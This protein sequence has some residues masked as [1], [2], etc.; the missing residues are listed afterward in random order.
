MLSLIV[1]GEAIFTLPFHI[2]RY[3]RPSFVEV[4]ALTQT[5][6]GDML[7]IYGVVATIAYPL[8]G[9]LADRFPVRVLLPTS[10]LMT[11]AGG[12]A[13]LFSPSIATM[14]W[15]YAFWGFSTILPFWAAL[16]KATRQWGG[17]DEQ[18]MA[19]G[20]LDGGR[21]LLAF[22]LS[23]MAVALFELLMPVAEQTATLAEKTAAIRSTVYVYVG[24]C[25]AAAVFT[26]LFVPEPVEETGERSSRR[27]AF[28]KVLAVVRMPAVWLQ[29]LIIV[30]A[31]SAFKGIDYYSQFAA[32][33]WGWTDVDAANLVKYAAFSR[34]FAAVGAGLLADRFSSSRVLIACFALAG[35]SY[36]ALV[37]A[38]PSAAHAWMLWT[39]VLTGCLGFFALRGV[40]FALLEESHIPADMT[41]TAVGVVSL[42]GFTPEIFMPKLGG[43]LL[44]RWPGEAT[45]FHLLYWFLGG[46]CVVGIVSTLTLRWLL[47]RQNA[48]Q[49]AS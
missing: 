4:F 33:V 43:W 32:D 16:I 38:A 25:V 36:I 15:L 5:E 46:A 26:W 7:A 29:S 2:I 23:L 14:N 35:G 8:G 21:G 44:D 17:D 18:G 3:F 19:F 45:G 37:F 22:L 49:A 48:R 40:Y 28:A 34:A 20:I 47:G 27:E 24:A 10:L 42:L 12:L 13:L 11:G 30:A 6:L 9:V 1:A 41:G 31:Y 39:A